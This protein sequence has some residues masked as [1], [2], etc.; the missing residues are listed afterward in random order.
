[1]KLTKPAKLPKLPT[2]KANTGVG[3]PA[4]PQKLGHIDKP[5][6]KYC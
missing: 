5:M 2:E 6:G 4:K 1:M 3:K